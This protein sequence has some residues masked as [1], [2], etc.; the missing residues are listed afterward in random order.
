MISKRAL[1]RY[2]DSRIR[3]YMDEDQPS[4][5]LGLLHK[6]I[7]VIRASLRKKLGNNPIDSDFR[8]AERYID[9]FESG[10]SSS[11]L[12]QGLD[13]IMSGVK[14]LMG[15]NLPVDLA[16]ETNHAK[17]VVGLVREAIKKVDRWR[18][19]N[20]PSYEWDW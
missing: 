8:E 10:R 7:R 20:L 18:M 1:K 15:S 17:K 14:R 9:M 13:S 5:P 3:A 6:M 12:K 16:F 2:I 4:L 11:R 19:N